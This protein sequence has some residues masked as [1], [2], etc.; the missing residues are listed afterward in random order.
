MRVVFKVSST[1]KSLVTRETN[2][3][4]QHLRTCGTT[5]LEWPHNLRL[6]NVPESG[7]QIGLSLRGVVSFYV[8]LCSS[9]EQKSEE[10]IGHGQ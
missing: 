1:G 10:E 5:V 4:L 6:S 8:I 3:L 9:T 7:K 2:R